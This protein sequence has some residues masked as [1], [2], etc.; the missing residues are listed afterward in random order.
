MRSVKK[1]FILVSTGTWSISLNPFTK[2]LLTDSET[3]SGCINYMRINGKPV[4]SSRLFLGNEYD[5]QVKEMTK[6]F[7]VDKS[8]HKSVKFDQKIYSEIKENHQSSFRWK[9]I[10]HKDM[11]ENTSY[12]YKTFEEAYHHL[13]IEIVMLQVEDIKRISKNQNINRLYVDGGFTDNE[14]YVKLLSHYL[15]DMKLRTTQASLG[16]ALGA[17]IAISDSK[18]N[19]KFLKRNYSLKKHVPFITT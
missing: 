11:P 12:P 13:M 5:L 7:G 14:I 3:E 8:L 15:R 4:K 19:S 10:D 9:S 18:L 1:K 17:A 16:S 6:A 2:E